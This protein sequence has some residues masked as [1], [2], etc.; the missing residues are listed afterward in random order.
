M[1]LLEL[2]PFLFDFFVFDSFCFLDIL[3]KTFALSVQ[4]PLV[5]FDLSRLLFHFAALCLKLIILNLVVL[6]GL[7]QLLC[8]LI[9]QILKMLGKLCGNRGGCLRYLGLGFFLLLAIEHLL[10]DV[11]ARVSILMLLLVTITFLRFRLEQATLVS[12]L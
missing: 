2:S 9:Q 12:R 3:Q 4:F 5:N 8:L 11:C 1:S 7:F 10:N 6:D